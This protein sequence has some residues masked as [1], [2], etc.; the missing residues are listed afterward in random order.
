MTFFMDVAGATRIT[1]Y[2]FLS[3]FFALNVGTTTAIPVLVIIIVS[4]DH[5]LGKKVTVKRRKYVVVELSVCFF[6]CEKRL[7]EWE[8]R[9]RKNSFP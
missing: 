5:R 9:R 8:S 2:A 6:S 3:L 7:K 1:L 4:L